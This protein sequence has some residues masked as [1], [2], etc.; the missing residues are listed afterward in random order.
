MSS[1]RAPWFQLSLR[2]LSLALAV[3]VS[4][5]LHAQGTGGR[6]LGRIA[7]PSGA[8]LS[9]VK[10]VATNDA[11]GVAHD[12]LSNDSGDYVFPDLPVGTYSLT[13][14]LTGFK[15]AVRHAITLDVNQVITL[16]MTMPLGAAQEVV[17][18]TSDAPLVE[19]SSTQLGAVVNNRSVNELP[20]N[21]RDSY[22]FLQL[23]PGVQSQLGSS[24]GTFYGS[25]SAG[26]VSVNGGRDRANNFSVNGGD[27]ND[28]FV[29]LPTIQPTPDAIEEFRVISNTFDAEYGRNSGAVVN[30]VTKSGANQWH[31]NV[32]EYFRNK[33]LNAQGF[34][35]TVK[36]QFNQNQ[37]GGTFGG[38]LRKDRT[39]FFTSYEGRRIRQGVSG[40]TVIV[41]T[42]SERGGD[43]SANGAFQ[44]GIDAS[45]G[46]P[47]LAQA[48]DGRANP[49]TG[50]T[51]D[52]ALG[53]APNGIAGL[54]T[55]ANPN[56]NGLP[57]IPWS[58][59]FPNSVI[60]TACQDPVAIDLLRF[61]PAANR[62]D[63]VTYQ[64]V[65]SSADNQ[66]QFTVRIDHHI[67]DHQNFSFYY[68]YTDDKSFQPF[69]NFQASGANIPGFGAK[70]GSRYQQYNPSHTWTISNSLVNEARFTYMREGQLTFQHP[71]QTGSV[72]NSCTSAVPGG[73]CFGGTSDSSAINTL[74]ANQVA[75]G[76]I[77]SASKAGITTGLPANRTGVPFVNV[78]GG[79][80]IGN[81]WEGELP[82]VGN[83][84]MF[85][86][87]LTWVK[88]N[89]T[90]KFG[91]DVRRARF[92]QT[93]YY[94]VSGQETFNS[95]TIN[96]VISA[97]NYPGYLLGI[98][99]SYV[100]GSAQRENV[101]TTGLYLFAQDSWKVNPQLTVNYGLRWE[102][103]TPLTDV[104]RHV[105]T[106]RPGQNSTVYPCT[107]TANE[108][109][110][111][112]VSACADAGV[113]PTGLVVPGDK[114]VP[115][116]M[117]QTYYKA[118]APRIGIAYSPNVTNGVLGK[119]FGANGKT[120]IR[121]GWGLFYNPMEQLVLEQFGAEPPFGGSTFLPSTF[122]N[123]PFVPQSG[124]SVNPNPFSGILSPTP[125]SAQDWSVF[126]PMLLYGDFQP[127]MRT[128]YTAQYN[129][130]I[131]RELAKDVVLQLGYVGSQG[132]RLLA[133]H[134]INAANPQSCLGIAALAATNQNWVTDGFGNNTSCGPFSEDNPYLISPQA[135]APAGGLVLP[136]SGN[137]GGKPT[138]IPGG[139]SISTVAPNGIYLAGLRPYSSPNCNPMSGGGVGS[140]CPLD[141][142]PV[143][144]NIFAEDT[145]APS[146]YNSFQAS[147]EKRFSHGLQLQAAYTLSKSLDWASS[148]EET[149][150]PFNYKSSRALSLFN[151]KQ[152]FVINY[153][154]DLPFRKYSGFA[155]KVI[156][157][158]QF[159][160]I[161]QFQ[162]G[163]PIRIQT[164]NDAELISSLFF[165]SADAPQLTSPLQIL[166][167]KKNG[168]QYLNPSQ[169]TDP[170]LGSFS[171]TPRSICCGPGENQWDIT[172]AKRIAFTESKYFQFRA[173]IFNLFNKTQFVNPDGNFSN[174]TF[175]LIQQARDPRLVQF[176][177]KFY[178]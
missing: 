157:G 123:T 78:A 51:C 174:T 32:Y 79:F 175:G 39:F 81:G 137:G 103:D 70:V 46:T 163:F 82:Q 162:S 146:A 65:P 45:A 52:N 75:S 143:F 125:G 77:P 133:S 54:P 132:H 20:L 89:H 136:Y 6:I 138:L 167:P 155:G 139:T 80:A 115:A 8:V 91:G 153:V 156:N 171:T 140:G 55:Q 30:V 114:G 107:L 144:T 141:G 128:Q 87:N 16:N 64:A 49:A 154:W 134:D 19:T 96:S 122:L 31:G 37:F 166:N 47:F 93:L 25:D 41:P 98:N 148:F 150:N 12:A 95:S 108:Q 170:N 2:V 15:K 102:L 66:D 86:D 109:S 28:Q 18:V 68:Y 53:L 176:A 90:L 1:V 48:L 61:V 110:N 172:L 164:Q 158:W 100:Q 17:D 113:Q 76:A 104:L 129:F 26:S 38:P 40:Q 126:R 145:I 67:N 152:R 33:V 119:V 71:Q 34:F 116:G 169:F 56:N 44:G 160:G 5:P 27:A 161:I 142:V 106:F 97:D 63:G 3:S 111:F 168:G 105:Q 101:R 94:S 84:F 43:F 112:G 74:I 73:V 42:S 7:D 99:D 62:A 159:S 177:L 13:F 35:N 58:E 124:G 135:V 149:V 88:G 59:V 83:S 92:D 60:P 4:L 14:D 178:F 9:A 118:I 151:S 10:V 117:T 11:T 23:Q 120:S 21:A 24:G 121:T 36:P 127:K 29:N 57:Y 72:Q 173:D 130:T 131:Q 147:L 22:Q 85:A 50:Q 165:L 69:Y